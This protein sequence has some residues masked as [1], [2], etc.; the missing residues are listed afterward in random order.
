MDEIRASF[1]SIKSRLLCLFHAVD[2]IMNKLSLLSDT[3]YF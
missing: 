2:V 1:I 3:F